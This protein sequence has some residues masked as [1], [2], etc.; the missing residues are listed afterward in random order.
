MLAPATA[1]PRRFRVEL[2]AR[3]DLSSRVQVFRFRAHGQFAWAA[4][5]Y[6]DLLLPTN[7]NGTTKAPY[8]I[9]S[10]ADDRFPNEFELA[11]ARGG[12]NPGLDE[13]ATGTEFDA[14]GPRGE[15][16]WHAA[17]HDCAALLVGVG[18]GV[19]PLRALIHEQIQRG[20]A[21]E[22]VLLAGSRS[23]SDML[24]GRELSAL[25]KEHPRF[26]FEP[27]LSMPTNEWRGRRGRVQEH[28]SELL[29]PFGSEVLVYVCGQSAMVADVVASLR[30]RHGLDSSRIKGEGY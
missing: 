23:E 1:L 4:G 7:G 3:S 5:Q 14:D 18:T 17:Q 10:I 8:S 27:T 24:W 11:V 12:S 30:A 26:R 20:G 25:A 21:N 2:I 9:A 22:L 6:V 15:F 16:V 28:V 13:I 29:A 19:A